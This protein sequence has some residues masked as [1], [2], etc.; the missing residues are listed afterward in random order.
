M[1]EMKLIITSPNHGSRELRLTTSASIGRSVDNTI[2]ID[3][4]SVARYH[5]MI[6]LRA[7]HFWLSDLGSTNGTALNGAPLKA[8]TQLKVGD[9]IALGGNSAIKIISPEEQAA[10]AAQP[11]PDNPPPAPPVTGGEAAPP[12]PAPQESGV[13]MAHVAVAGVTVFV[14]LVFIGVALWLINNK[15]TTAKN[16]TPQYSTPLPTATKT[17]GTKAMPT[18]EPTKP[19]VISANVATGV[20]GL[21]RTLAGQLSGRSNYIF[22][23]DMTAQIAARTAEYRLDVTAKAR[24]YQLEVDRAFGNAKGL[25]PLL[26]HILA[27][28]QSKYGQSTGAGIGVWQVPPAIAKDYLQP[29]EDLSALNPMKRSAEVAASHLDELMDIFESQ[30]FMY[31]L[32]CYGQP[33]S[34]AGALNQKLQ[35]IDPND[36]RDFWK[37]VKSG[38]VPREG[39]EKV[40]RFF[41]A[42]IVGEN[43]G[44]FGLNAKPFSEL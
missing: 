9:T 15:S 34:V 28:S 4:P 25:K 33:K 35:G 20:E 40:V 27:M 32:A 43:P 38:L 41:A 23:P 37:Q 42:G 6:E 39:A 18:A 11:A 19:V 36:R 21:A 2:H 31:A 12:A 13:S 7:D 44:N 30:D 10:P 24:E 8:A 14:L 1:A 3:D 29:G 26:G 22:D 17:T 16:Q 5:A